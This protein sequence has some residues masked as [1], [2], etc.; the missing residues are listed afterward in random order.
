MK[1]SILIPTIPERAN[2]LNALVSNLNLQID[3]L[4]N[5]HPSLGVVQ[6]L[7]D[8]SKKFIEGGVTVGEKRNSLVQKAKGDYVCFLDDDDQVPN[9]YIEELIRATYKNTDIITFKSLFKCDTYWGIADMSIQNKNAE[10]TPLNQFKRNAW[11]VCPVRRTIAQ[12]YKFP[13]KN[14]AEDWQWMEQVLSEVK[15]EC[16]IDMILHQYN[17]SHLTSAVDEIERTNS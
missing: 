8:D 5:I 9:N 14:N 12:K 17:H 15:S 7:I 4:N 10:A 3:I 1:L 13:F 2:K 16:K 6:I 11:H